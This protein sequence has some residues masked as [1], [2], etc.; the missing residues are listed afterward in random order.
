[1]RKGFLVI[2]AVVMS[3]MLCASAAAEISHPVGPGQ[4]GYDA[5][6][7]SKNI[8]IRP[9]KNANAKAVKRLNYGDR[10]A[11]MS[12]GDGWCEVYL[13]DDHPDGRE[14][15]ADQPAGSGRM[16]AETGRRSQRNSP[17]EDLECAENGKGAVPQGELLDQG[18][19]TE[20]LLH[21]CGF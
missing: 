17:D 21:F 11:V 3:L 15:A 10:M 16:D 14:L 20:Q 12:L 1:M 6:V 19:R 5:V 13:S 18:K 9:T 8:S 4:L 7:L 2:C